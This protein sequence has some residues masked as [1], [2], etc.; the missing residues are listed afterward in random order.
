M[1]GRDDFDFTQQPH[2]YWIESLADASREIFEAIKNKVPTA[3]ITKRWQK[4][5]ELVAWIPHDLY[6]RLGL[7][8]EA[9]SKE[10]IGNKKCPGK[11]CTGAQLF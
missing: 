11:V 10:A 7:E 8:Q 5:A 4:V 3:Y 9:V 6:T 2:T 1:G